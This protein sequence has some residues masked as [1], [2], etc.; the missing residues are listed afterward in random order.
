MFQR[1]SPSKFATAV[2]TA[3]LIIAT[4]VT[5][6]FCCYRALLPIEIDRN[7]AWNAWQSKSLQH[8]YPNSEALISNNYPPLYFYLLHGFSG[9]GLEEIYAGRALSILAAIALTLL[10]YR[11]VLIVGM[12]K[13][14]AAAGAVWF[15]ATLALG[16]TGYI[17]M[18]DPHL[19]AL[20]VM[21]AG[22]VWL[23][24]SAKSGRAC[25]PAVLVMVLAGFIK[26]NTIAIPVAAIVWLAFQSPRRAARA[27]VFGSA[28]CALGL[29]VCRAAYGA[30]FIEQLPVP[31]HLSLSHSQLEMASPQLLLTGSVI[32][33]VWL[34]RDRRFLLAQRMAALLFLTFVSGSVQRLGDGVDINAYFEFLFALAIGVGIAFGKVQAL[35]LAGHARSRWAQAGFSRFYCAWVFGFRGTHAVPADFPRGVP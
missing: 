6:A 13:A 32:V 1:I 15:L 5:L 11:A 25:E 27:A 18:N 34:W 16:F 3:V 21:C 28:A 22:F 30:E 24:A 2:L 17:G 8:L 4:A 10:V 7:E 14:A 26:H 19:I 9:I 33:A 20:A 23:I 31:R 35:P 29:F 12:T